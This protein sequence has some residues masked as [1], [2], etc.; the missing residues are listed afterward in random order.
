[1]TGPEIG[2]SLR[3]PQRG[4][5]FAPVERQA[6]VGHQLVGGEF[7]RLFSGQDRGDD[8]RGEEAQPNDSRCI[9]GD[10]PFLAGDLLESGTARLEQS[11][12]ELLG[13][14]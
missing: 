8:V 11:C 5:L 14:D 3:E 12:A 10:D 9:G 6:R 1:M 13:S 7:G 2:V 4:S